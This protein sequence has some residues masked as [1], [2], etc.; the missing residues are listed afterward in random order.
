MTLASGRDLALIYFIL[1]GVVIALIPLAVF[2]LAIKG[3]RVGRR[4]MM[5]YVHLAQ[6]YAARIARG[7]NRGSERI[8]KPFIVA[9][10]VAQRVRTFTA[11]F[12]ERFGLQ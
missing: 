4:R 6:F 1:I 11:L 8:T 5:P 12:A 7:T 10:G 2:A 3:L 9:A